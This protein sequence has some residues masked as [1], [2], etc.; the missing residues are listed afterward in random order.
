MPSR[1]VAAPRHCPVAHALG[2][3]GD[4]WS[5]LVMREVLHGEHRFEAIYQYTGAPR[6][7]LTD[8]LRKLVDAGLLE[9]RPYNASAT[10]YAY[11][12]TAKGERVRPIL[13]ALAEFGELD[14]P[15]LAGAWRDFLVA[16]TAD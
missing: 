8:R 10:R 3:F 4:R 7:V 13:R 9:R 2:L 5:L 14:D 11:Y 16:P 15:T 6:D 1:T 12:A